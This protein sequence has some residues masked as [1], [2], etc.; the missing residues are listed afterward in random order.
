[1]SR[2]GL[3]FHFDYFDRGL[4]SPYELVYAIIVAVDKPPVCLA[5]FSLSVLSLFIKLLPVSIKLDL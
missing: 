5:C 1:M 4:A 2:L 3:T